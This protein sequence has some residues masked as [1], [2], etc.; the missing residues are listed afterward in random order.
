MKRGEEH[1]AAAGQDTGVRNSVS[2]LSLSGAINF[3]GLPPPPAETRNR[4]PL[5]AASVNTMLSSSPQD[6]AFTAGTGAMVTGGPPPIAIFFK[7]RV[8]ES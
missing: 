2:P 5:T 3:S 8:R 4:P 6:A 7:A 1:R